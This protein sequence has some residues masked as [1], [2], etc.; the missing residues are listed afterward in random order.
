ME[1]PTGCRSRPAT[2]SERSVVVAAGLVSSW[3][4]C[5][6]QLDVKLSDDP[7]RSSQRFRYVDNALLGSRAELRLWYSMNSDGH[8][9]IFD[10]E[11]PFYALDTRWAAATKL[12]SDERQEKLYSQGEAVEHFQHERT[13]AEIRGGC[14]RRLLPCRAGNS[15]ARAQ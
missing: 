8:R 1:R 15:P 4:C 13:M 2:T 11:R 6:R 12:V 7:D 10:L 5:F 14:H 3:C 9:R